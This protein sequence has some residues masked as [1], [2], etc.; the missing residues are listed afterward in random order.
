ME[1]TPEGFF[2]QLWRRVRPST[3]FR[4]RSIRGV[5]GLTVL[6][7]V[8]VA[9][10][11]ELGAS[12]T[13]SLPRAP[14]RRPDILLVTVDALRA[15]H[16]SSRGYAHLTTPTIDAFA[17]RSVQFTNAIAQAPYTKA[18]I[19]SLMTGLYPSTHQAVTA[20]VPFPETMT[21]HLTSLPA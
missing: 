9:V 19:A 3:L 17:R 14:H 6:L 13:L 21:G 8:A 16:L 15:D 10:D 7:G 11:F 1:G 4:A 18:S 12:V 5:F 2:R 20:T